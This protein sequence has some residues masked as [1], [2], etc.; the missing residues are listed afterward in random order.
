MNSASHPAAAAALSL[1][2]FFNSVNAAV[3]ASLITAACNGYSFNSIT[4]GAGIG[5]FTCTSIFLTS[6]TT[7][8][9]AN[10]HGMDLFVAYSNGLLY[11]SLGCVLF[12]TSTSSI[13]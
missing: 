2:A 6:S 9:T 11:A 3:I 13:L 5:S 1:S 4:G 10:K 7:A 8:A 12:K